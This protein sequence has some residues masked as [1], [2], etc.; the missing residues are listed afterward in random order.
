[1]NKLS[2][3]RVI[4]NRYIFSSG[5]IITSKSEKPLEY[6]SS[7]EK[8]VLTLLLFDQ[9]IK[10]IKTQ[11]LTIYWKDQNKN[12][13]YTP[14]I[15][16]EF[17]GKNNEI[18][19]LMIEVKPNDILFTEWYKF[20]TRFRMTTKWCRERGYLFKLITEKYIDTIYLSNVNFLLQYD[21]SRFPISDLG[22]VTE[23]ESQV[24]NILIHQHLSI[25]EL[26]QS[27]SQDKKTQQQLLPYIWMLV[28][29]GRLNVDLTTQL[30]MNTIIW[31]GEPPFDYNFE[32]SPIRRRLRSRI[33]T[34]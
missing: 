15:Y 18:V 6:E 27:L 20:I 12:K 3:G 34:P 2:A 21:Q 29:D 4:H 10:Y 19:R 7:L 8:N 28:R 13:R 11:P 33:I 23:I 25:N 22:I 24:H 32:Q 26:L 16:L 1:M 30:T 31:N 5:K 14:D 17:E 9:S